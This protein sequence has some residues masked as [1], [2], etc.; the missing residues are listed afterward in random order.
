MGNYTTSLLDMEIVIGALSPSLSVVIPNS[1]G[2]LFVVCARLR[3]KGAVTC[4]MRIWLSMPLKSSRQI[5]ERWWQPEIVSKPVCTPGY[6]QRTSK[7]ND[8]PAMESHFRLR[9]GLCWR[10]MCLCRVCLQIVYI[11][12]SLKWWIQLIENVKL[13]LESSVTPWLTITTVKQ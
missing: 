12:I 2:I 7:K 13:N 10:A 8:V 6:T 11:L 1:H 5:V 9:L 4:Y 3:K